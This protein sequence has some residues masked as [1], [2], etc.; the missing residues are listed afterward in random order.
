M[1]GIATRARPVT[2]LTTVARPTGV[3]TTAGVGATTA[4]MTA[5][6]PVNSFTLE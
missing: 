4:G 5:M 2:Q 6:T 3:V 1:T